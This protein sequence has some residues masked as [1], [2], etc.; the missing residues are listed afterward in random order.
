M[1]FSYQPHPDV[2]FRDTQ[3]CEKVRNVKRED[4]DKHPNKDFRIHV[5]PDS[6]LAW[7][8]MTDQFYRLKTAMDEGRE[9]S[10]MMGN[11]NPGYANLAY[12]INRFQVNCEKLWVFCV[13]EWADQDGKVAPE[14]YPQGFLHSMLKYFY[15]EIEEHLRPPREQ[16]MCPNDENVN[17]YSKILADRGGADVCYVGPG[18][19]GHAAFIDPNVPEW[20]KDLEEYKKQGTQ[21][22]SVHLLTVA[23]NSLHASFGYSGDL[24]KVPPKAATIGPADVLGAKYRRATSGLTTA[25]THVSWQRFITRLILHGPVTPQVPMSILQETETD[26][27]VSENIA[28]NIEPVWHEGY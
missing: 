19:A 23:Q 18:W 2:P 10:F 20:S 1:T 26:Y 13:D 24:A 21:V 3:V 14:S 17:D 22:V 5:V 16:I 9:I 7:I 28:R 12:M 15:S 6:R 27:Y 4:I 25:G 11:P 8:Q